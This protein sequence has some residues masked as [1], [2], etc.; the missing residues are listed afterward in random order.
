MGMEPHPAS[1]RTA[2]DGP[3]DFS[4]PARSMDVASAERERTEQWVEQDRSLV[5]DGPSPLLVEPSVLDPAEVQA[6]LSDLHALLNGA[7]VRA[8]RRKATAPP[9]TDRSLFGALEWLGRDTAAGAISGGA[10][11]AAGATAGP[12]EAMAMVCH[13]PQL[14]TSRAASEAHSTVPRRRPACNTARGGR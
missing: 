10:T 8:P 2:A 13:Q 11:G 6:L 12:L 3:S 14:T 7:S 4:E 1:R 5:P 9:S